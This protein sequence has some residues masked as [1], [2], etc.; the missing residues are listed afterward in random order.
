MKGNEVSELIIKPALRGRYF[1]KEAVKLFGYDG[2]I[3]STGTPYARIGDQ[4]KK[5]PVTGNRWYESANLHIK[6]QKHTLSRRK[7]I[8][9]G[10]SSR[11]CPIHLPVT[12]LVFTGLGIA[13]HAALFAGVPS[14]RGKREGLG[15]L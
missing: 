15:K 5:R 9:C 13:F 14:V 6:Y 3:L 12:S 7:P 11:P 2:V 4:I 10:R 1:Q 8:G